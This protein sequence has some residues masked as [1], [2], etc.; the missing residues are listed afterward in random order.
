MKATLFVSTDFVDP[1]AQVRPTLEDVWAGNAEAQ[2]LESVGYLSWDELRLAEARGVFD[3]QSHGVTH[4]WYFSGEGVVD[5]RHPQDAYFWMDWNRDRAGKWCW[6]PYDGP[7]DS[8]LGTPVYEWGKGLLVRRYFPNQALDEHMRSFVRR[9]GGRAFFQGNNWRAQLVQ[10]LQELRREGYGPGHFEDEN[11]HR[12]RV[13]QELRASKATIERELGKQ[14]DFLCWPFDARTKELF[15]MAVQ[16]VGYK[17][18]TGGVDFN[19]AGGDPR[20][21]T[22]AFAGTH[23]SSRL[24]R[25]LDLL[26]FAAKVNLMRGEHACLVITAPVSLLKRIL[27]HRRYRGR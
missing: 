16:E 27:G 15:R 13:T 21:I 25:R 4:T 5:F 7:E 6:L 20:Q 24:G 22:R 14:V 18:T 1:R 10:R 8:Q 17:A 2:S 26:W 12:S 3:I 23:L 11:E 19:R 9:A